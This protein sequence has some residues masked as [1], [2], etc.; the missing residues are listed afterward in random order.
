MLNVGRMSPDHPPFTDVIFDMDGVLCASEPFIA[1]AACKMFAEMH[2]VTVQPLDFVPFVGTGED[3]FIGGVAEKYGVT[4]VMPRDKERTYAIYL[5]IIKGRLQP[6]PGVH[7]FIADCRQRGVKLAVATSADRVKLDGN[8]N[9]IGV[10]AQTFDACITGSEIAHKKPDPEI[11][12]T[13]ARR[14]GVPA[15]RCLVIEDAPSGV[16]AAKRAGS[17][18]LGLTTSFSA[19]QLIEAG[20]DWVSSDLAHVPAEIRACFAGLSSRGK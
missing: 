15:T 4:L 9:E 6:L 20:A 3:R 1:E 17:S 5:E 7:E 13:A 11:F 16:Q 18:C 14:L 12:L 2:G 8:L 10:P 19:A